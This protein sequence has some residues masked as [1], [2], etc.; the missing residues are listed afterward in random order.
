MSSPHVRAF[1]SL[2]DPGLPP[3]RHQT[4]Y[5]KFRASHSRLAEPEAVTSDQWRPA[6][7]AGSSPAMWYQLLTMVSPKAGPI[8]GRSGSWVMFG[9]AWVGE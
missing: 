6:T 8:H 1:H 4:L 7:T 5:G 9:R 3:Q 2:S